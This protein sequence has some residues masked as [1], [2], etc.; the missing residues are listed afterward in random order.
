MFR[1][2]A[3]FSVATVLTACQPAAAPVVPATPE[4]A[5]VLPADYDWRWR[6]NLGFG[7]LNFGETDREEGVDV[8]T[9]TCRANSKAVQVDWGG[10]G[11]AT[12]SSG[13]ASA[14]FQPG[15]STPLAH[16]VIAALGETAALT[17]TK[18]G[19]PV[20]LT[21]KATGRKAIAGFLN[22]CSRPNPEAGPR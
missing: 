6:G 16:P 4:G 8:L 13:A 3:I 14:V 1:R 20:I 22:Y 2:I 11:P 10:D 15:A 21:G 9:L 5:S 18:D 7:H 17:L 19:H 12:L